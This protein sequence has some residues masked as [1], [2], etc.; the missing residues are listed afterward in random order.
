MMDLFFSPQ[1]VWFGLPAVLG[2][3]F[4]LLRMLLMLI[5]GAGIEL[6]GHLGDLHTD[7]HTDLH[8]SDVHHAD[9][10]GDAFKILSFQS[11]A[12][13]LMGF[14]WGGLA[15][16]IGPHWDWPVSFVCALACGI[17]MVWIL[18]LLFQVLIEMQ[19]SGNVNLKDAVGSEAHVYVS[20]PSAGEGRGQVRVVLNNTQRIVNAVSSGPSIASNARV[21]VLNVNADNTITVAEA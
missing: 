4:F 17:G 9:D 19:S 3:L 13:F 16:I 6:G 8:A 2:T 1:H 5:G 21:R 11:I 18:A 12:A 20:I 15:A 7:L 14:G 10:P